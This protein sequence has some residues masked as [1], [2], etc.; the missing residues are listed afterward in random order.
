MQRQACLRR[1]ELCRSPKHD[2]SPHRS[3]VVTHVTKIAAIFDRWRSAQLTR[4]RF[5]TDIPR[6]AI[7]GRRIKISALQDRHGAVGGAFT[8]ARDPG[9]RVLRGPPKRQRDRAAPAVRLGVKSEFRDRRRREWAR[10]GSIGCAIARA[11]AKLRALRW[12]AFDCPL[13]PPLHPRGLSFAYS[14]GKAL[15]SAG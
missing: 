15:S 10:A 11:A 2:G 13:A 9:K 4:S 14:A 3:A 7:I 5:L 12:C 8:P 6:R 1:P